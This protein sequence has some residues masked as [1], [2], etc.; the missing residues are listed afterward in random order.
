MVME[1]NNSSE[2]P[3]E[4]S[5]RLDTNDPSF[6]KENS[7]Q[8]Q[9]TIADN[10]TNSE[11]NYDEHIYETPSRNDQVINW[12]GPEFVAYDK[13]SVWYIVS[14]TIAIVLFGLSYLLL[15]QIITSITLL[16]AV[17]SF[18]FYGL[19]KPK[20]IEYSIGETGITIGNKAFSYQDFRLFTVT[21]EANYLTINLIPIKRF[22]AS[23]GLFYNGNEPDKIIDF[24]ADRLPMEQH[25][26]DL[27]DLLMQRIK[28]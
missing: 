5:E 9:N 1:E 25:K 11:N 8:T 13:S 27:I 18:G 19:R 15:K 24:L 28:F 14:L 21:T 17:L 22:A 16:V 6:Y 26:S 2:D 4:H 20:N 12:L 3:N 23:A 10:S 7:N